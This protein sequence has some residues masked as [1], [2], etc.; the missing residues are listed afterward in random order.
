MIFYTADQHYCHNNIIKYTNRPFSSVGEMNNVLIKKY[1]ARVS[2]RDVC[3]HL[4]DFAMA[5]FPRWKEICSALNG[6]K[7]LI[8]GSHDKNAKKMKEVGFNEVHNQLEVDL[9]EHGIWLLNHE[10]VKTPKKLLCAHIHEKWR[11]LGKFVINVGVDVWNYEP[12]TIEELLQAPEDSWYYKC[13]NCGQ[14]IRRLENNEFH[15]K[16]YCKCYI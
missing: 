3:Y 11:R 4:G 13:I 7:I 1:N 10:P 6:Y 15:Y 5:S 9:G 8:K 14:T 12:V 16:G 2:S